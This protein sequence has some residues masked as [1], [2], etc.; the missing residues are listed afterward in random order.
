MSI[1]PQA[2]EMKLEK[3]TLCPE[4]I[5]Q[6]L[7]ALRKEQIHTL[8]TIMAIRSS[9]IMVTEHVFNPLP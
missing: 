7:L 1:K 6:N 3:R 5:T 4:N 9:G 8:L 2:R